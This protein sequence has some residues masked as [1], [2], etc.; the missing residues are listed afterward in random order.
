MVSELPT[1]K[2]KTT[3]RVPLI[4]IVNDRK[5]MEKVIQP[6]GSMF[7]SIKPDLGITFIEKGSSKKGP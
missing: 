3:G 7:D 1:S 4:K 6:Q 5:N 2:T